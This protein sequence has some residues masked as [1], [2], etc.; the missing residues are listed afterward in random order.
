MIKKSVFKVN[1]QA[2][3][4]VAVGFLSFSSALYAAVSTPT[5]D[6][7][8]RKPVASALGHNNDTRA[9]QSVAASDVISATYTFTDP[10]LDP[11]DLTNTVI[12]WYRKSDGSQVGTGA[13][14]T[15]VAGDAPLGVFYT[16]T[17][18]TDVLTTMP[19]VGDLVT[20]PDIPVSAEDVLSVAITAPANPIV[21]T[22]I[23]A[24]PTC[25]PVAVCSGP[26][27]YAWEVEDGTGGWVGTGTNSNTYT[28]VRTDQLK[29][30]RVTAT[31][32]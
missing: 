6:V 3:L 21:G 24:T 13:T 9:G 16:I 14:Y 20:S 1:K 4:Y 22:A 19:A 7:W 30:I 31:K 15:A 29:K 26:I 17:P 27:N 18:G 25:T 11:Q 12:K 5:G 32:P 10:D 8:G 28:P 23:T 2:A